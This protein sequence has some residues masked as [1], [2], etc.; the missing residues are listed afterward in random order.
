MS[1][2][3]HLEDRAALALRLW[4]MAGILLRVTRL[5][6]RFDGLSL[7]YYS[8]PW[9][10]MAAAF[11]LLAAHAWRRGR[12]HPVRRY[13]AFTVLALVVW[14]STSWYSAPAAGGSGGV[15]VVH[16]N[17][18]RPD[19]RL[20]AAAAWLRGQ[21]ADVICLA[22]V[23]PKRRRTIERWSAAFPEYTLQ[24]APE[25]LLCLV[26]GEVL[27]SETGTL[28]PHSTY[29][30]HR[31]RVRGRELQVLQVDLIAKPNRSRRE[32]LGRLTEIA[33]RAGGNLVVAG[34][35]NTPVES[36]HLRGLREE[37][38]NA[39]EAAGHGFVETWP[40]FAPALSLDQVWLGSRLSA[41]GCAN[42]WTF[43]S[44]HRPV[45]VTAVPRER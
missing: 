32:P 5:R 28:G 31:V 16:W 19:W 6:D 33:R 20:G 42:R 34:D 37:C 26:R 10:V 4:I 29:A 39:F 38:T 11:V 24:Q 45:V 43:L 22:E 1:F 7:V 3:R 21:D 27:D 17:V 2:L 14:V 36:I 18:G 41:A 15:R 30:L 44:D 23:E 12:M 13:A 8:T 9:P 35:F 40:S 25:N